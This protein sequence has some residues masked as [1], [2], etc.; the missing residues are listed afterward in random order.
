MT[1]TPF[2]AGNWKMNTT[3]QEGCELTRALVQEV[4]ALTDIKMA[5]CPPFVYLAA[6]ADALA[7]SKIAL[8]AQNMFYEPKGAFTGQ[9][10]AEMLKDSCCTYVICGHSEPRHVFGETDALVNQ[11]VLKALAVGLKPILCV[12][13]TLEEREAGR[14]MAVVERHV[15]WGLYGVTPEQAAEVTIAYEP[16][17]AIGTGKTAEP[18]DAQKVHVFIR[19]LLGKLLGN[20]IADAMPIQYGGSVK[21]KNADTLAGMS[22]IDGFLVGGA[23]LKAAEFAQIIKKTRQVKCG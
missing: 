6:V 7:D 19:E 17:W 1:R 21:E 20:A 9:I 8:G 5:V 18:E 12:G 10:S 16:V 22:E 15:A 3:A 4:G 14:T 13:E 2:V 23:S 11:K